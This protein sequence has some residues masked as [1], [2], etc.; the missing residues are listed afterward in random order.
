VEKP[1]VAPGAAAPV[2]HAQLRA[3]KQPSG[4]RPRRGADLLQQRASPKSDC[5]FLCLGDV[6]FVELRDVRKGLEA[7]KPLRDQRA[8]HQLE[9][10]LHQPNE[11]LRHGPYLHL[12][13]AARTLGFVLDQLPGLLLRDEFG[14]EQMVAVR[15]QAD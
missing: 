13:P 9:K 12:V 6:E 3:Q 10:Q 4:A 8:L 2:G 15:V 7:E 14:F 1:R 5:V 11:I